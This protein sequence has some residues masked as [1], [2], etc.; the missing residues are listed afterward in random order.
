MG[1][2]KV[3][4][5]RSVPLHFMYPKSCMDLKNESTFLTSAPQLPQEPYF[6]KVSGFACSSFF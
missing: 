4:A 2:T 1:K 5:N 3:L 6:S